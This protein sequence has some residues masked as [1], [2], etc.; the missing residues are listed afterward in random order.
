M[1]AILTNA[2]N[3]FRVLV[4]SLW[5]H[6]VNKLITLSSAFLV[7]AVA[8]SVIKRARKQTDNFPEEME[9]KKIV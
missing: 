9:R 4:V 8:Q 2:L 1:V 6:S 3:A 5:I 7:G